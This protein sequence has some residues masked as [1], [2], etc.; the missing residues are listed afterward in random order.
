MTVLIAGATG[1]LG[2]AMVTELKAR[3]VV[4]RAL[5]RSASRL[6]GLGADSVAVADALAGPDALTDA[7][8]GVTRVFSCLG[9]SVLP[10][11]SSLYQTYD[12]VDRRGNLNLIEAAKRAGVERFTYVSVA[13]SDRMKGLQYADA[14]EA[15]VDGLRASGLDY[16]VVR[17]TGFFCAFGEFLAMA[18]KGA[19]PCIGNPSVKTN[20][21]DERDLAIICSDA[22]LQPDFGEVTVG[23]PQI[24]SRRQ[25]IEAVFSAVAKPVKIRKVPAALVRFGSYITWPF[26]PR[27]AHILRFYAFVGLNDCIADEHGSRT[28][29]DYFEELTART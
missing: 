10:S 5:G 26:A 11:F 25:I 7:F 18:R 14:H 3:G 28:I 12:R 27:L 20:P 23:G 17:P 9:A 29:A 13:L 6:E 8:D 16:A 15:V 1:A 22:V 21:I 2:R 19:V 4:V 24:L